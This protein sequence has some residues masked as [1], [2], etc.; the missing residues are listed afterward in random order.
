VGEE[1]SFLT[2]IGVMLLA[3]IILYIKW[4]IHG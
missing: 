3:F 4:L 2:C 1:A